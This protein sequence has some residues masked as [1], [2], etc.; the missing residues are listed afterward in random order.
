MNSTRLAIKT[1]LAG[2]LPPRFL[3]MRG[4]SWG[5]SLALTFDDGPHPERT[6]RVLDALEQHGIRATF[7]VVGSKAAEHPELIRRMVAAGHDVGHHSYSH[8]EPDA[9]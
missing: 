4:P 9:T 5:R 1:F 3:F 8:S 6:P 2:M 7:F